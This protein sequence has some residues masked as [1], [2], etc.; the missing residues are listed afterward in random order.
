MLPLPLAWLSCLRDQPPNCQRAHGNNADTAP[1]ARRPRGVFAGT[2]RAG[3]W[4]GGEAVR[5]RPRPAPGGGESDQSSE[6]R[7]VA[8]SPPGGGAERC[9]AGRSWD[10]RTPGG[11]AA[12]VRRAAPLPTRPTGRW[13]GGEAASTRPRPALSGSDFGRSYRIAMMI[14]LIAAVRASMN[15]RGKP[16][17]YPTAN[18][19][20]RRRCGLA[21]RPGLGPRWPVLGPGFSKEILRK[22]VIQPQVPLRLPCYDLVPITGFIFGA[23]LD[24]SGDFG[25]PPLWWL[26]GRCVQGSGTH[27]P[28]QC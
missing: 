23:C 4:P 11:A 13:P 5:G 8:R 21:G 15:P 14:S 12:G 17:G 16:A 28:R 19:G 26:D 9:V 7:S 25:C 18:K 2:A 22:E 24:G 1:A 6:E 3:R 27:S 10:V 20:G